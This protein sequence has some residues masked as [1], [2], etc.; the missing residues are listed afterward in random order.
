MT[1][2]NRMEKINS[3]ESNEQNGKDETGM[4]VKK[5]EQDVNDNTGKKVMNRM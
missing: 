5:T 2:M 3:N 1:V 4:K